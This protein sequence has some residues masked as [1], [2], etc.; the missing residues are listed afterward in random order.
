MSTADGTINK[1]KYIE[2]L[3]NNLGPLSLAIFLSLTSYF[4]T[5][6]TLFIGL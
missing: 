2:V 5:T 3:E 4:N 6:M 1:Y